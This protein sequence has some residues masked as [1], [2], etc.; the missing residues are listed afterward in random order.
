MFLK[1]KVSKKSPCGFTKSLLVIWG[2]CLFSPLAWHCVPP[3][4]RESGLMHVS[5]CAFPR[6]RVLLSVSDLHKCQA[7]GSCRLLLKNTLVF[8]IYIIHFWVHESLVLVHW[9]QAFS[10]LHKGRKSVQSVAQICTWQWQLFGA[11]S[12]SSDPNELYTSPQHWKSQA[13]LLFVCRT[14]HL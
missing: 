12:H 10:I 4:L 3:S 5:L 14:Y 11:L 9:R 8:N 2:A 13:V 6:K 7:K 1:M